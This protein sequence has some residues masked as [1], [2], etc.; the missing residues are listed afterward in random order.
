MTTFFI[1]KQ[2]AVAVQTVSEKFEYLAPVLSDIVIT[3]EREFNEGK[4]KKNRFATREGCSL[5]VDHDMII[6]Y[7]Q[8]IKMY[9]KSPDYLA[10][11][12]G[13]AAWIIYHDLI[14]RGKE[15]DSIF[16]NSA[17]NIRYEI[18]YGGHPELNYFRRD[19]FIDDVRA[20]L[21]FEEVPYL[22]VEEIYDRLVEKGG[23]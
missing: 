15:K 4:D 1:N 3:T 7:D 2:V 9:K 18:D 21:Q 17:S 10:F 14:Q 11:S 12:I 8:Y 13:W 22:S 23:E 16:W 19:H 5:G 20:E 6:I